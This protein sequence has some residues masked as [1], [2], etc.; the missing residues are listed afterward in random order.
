MNKLL[1]L[2]FI[3]F[4]TAC[5][6]D[7][8]S[9]FWTEQKK[10]DKIDKNI[11]V[12]FKKELITKDEFNR[13]LILDLGDIEE[14]KIEKA[15][16]TNNYGRVASINNINNKSLFKFSKI[17]DF[18]YFE[19]ELGIDSEGFIFF[20]SKSNV[21]K[22]DKN[23]EIIW[24]QNVYSKKEAKLNPKITFSNNKDYLVAF[25]NITK[26]FALDVKNG[27]LLWEKKNKNPFNSEVKIFEDKILVVDLNNFLICYSLIDGSELWRF[28][29]G[30]NFLKSEKRSSVAIINKVV[31]F[32]NSL[33]D[34]TAISI[35]DG[36]LLW[37]TPTQSSRIIE[38][39]FN[40][41]S[42]DLVLD[43]KN[44]FFSNNRNEFYS[45]NSE[46]GRVQWKQKINSIIRPVIIENF[47]FTVS[48][49]GYL[50][51]VEKNRGNILRITN[52][53]DFFGKKKIESFFNKNNENILPVGM[54]AGQK[55]L[56][57]TTTNGRLLVVDISSGQINSVIKLGKNKLSK[58]FFYD[59]N[60]IIIKENSVIKLN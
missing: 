36:S 58:P 43:N 32:S 21:I 19:P 35:K 10:I 24:K 20:D 13:E 37:Q 26:F 59:E 47:I 14:I 3:L 25:D 27:N 49:E 15:S 12:L 8:R 52:L 57:L 54:I 55:N 53:F 6:F 41:I 9:G 5:S 2:I 38:N 46:D 33:G 51:V 60:L 17:K 16:L 22:F 50:F 42:S 4:L 23:S 7:T 30:N 48:N 39:A 29:S 44:I 11:S 1:T 31:Y 34:I 18:I 28:G 45:L 40:L 56:Y